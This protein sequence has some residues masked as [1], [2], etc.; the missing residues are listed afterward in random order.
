[1]VFNS[2]TF[3][4][5][6]PITLVIYY[7]LPKKIKVYWLLIA[8]YYFYAS[9]NV[10]Y[11]VLILFSTFITY[12]SGILIAKAKT[13]ALKKWAVAG[14]LIINLSILFVFKYLDFTVSNINKLLNFG[15]FV[16]VSLPFSLILPVGISFYTFQALSYTIDVY[17]GDVEVCKNFAKYA[18]FVSFFP[19][20]VA[21]PIERSKNLISEIHR[22]EHEK[23]FNYEMFVKGAFIALY[24]FIMKMIVADRISI[25]VTSIYD[26]DAWLYCSGFLLFVASILFSFQIY[27]DFA[28]YTYIAIGTASMMGI[29]L[30]ENFNA[31]YLSL[32]LKEFWGKWHISLTSWF[33]D[34]LYFPLGGSQKG[35]IKK[36][37]NIL[38]VFL[39]SGLWH[40]AS[41]HYVA[42]GLLHGICRVFEDAT[43]K[44]RTL[45]LDKL[46]YNRNCF[47]HKLLCGTYTFSLVTLFWVFFRAGSTRQALEIIKRTFTDFG[48]WHLTDGSVLELGLDGNEF[49]VLIIFILLIIVVDILKRKKISIPNILLRQNTWFLFFVMFA[50][51]LLVVIF[52]VYGADYDAAAFI[53]F[54]F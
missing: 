51:I 35:K 34:Y 15:G 37:V 21:G 23:M 3:L 16:S 25:Y 26:T 39:V 40:G 54:Q 44:L 52:G 8:S 42:W 28:G 22:I 9:W 31:P 1:M 10:K 4:I 38:I 7:L 18:L 43:E 17:R 20:L 5:F 24:G 6:F 12:L 11:S 45:I 14:S 29:K 30:C 33:K 53:Y 36:Y 2:L 27:C 32:S 48:I 47:S 46:H 13:P 41:W 50:G 49:N 19:Q